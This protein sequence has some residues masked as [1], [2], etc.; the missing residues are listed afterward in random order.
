MDNRPARVPNIIAFRES[1]LNIRFRF[2]E[3]YLFPNPSVFFRVDRQLYDLTITPTFA[4]RIITIT[5]PKIEVNK[6]PN[7]IDYYLLK[8]G[9]SSLMGSIYV[10]MGGEDD[11]DDA[12]GIFEVTIVDDQTIVVYISSEQAV[13]DAIAAKD[14]AE[15]ARDVVLATT[16]DP[17]PAT[18]TSMLSLRQAGVKQDFTVQVDEYQGVD[19]VPYYWNG[20][21]LF[22]YGTE[23]PEE[24][25]LEFQ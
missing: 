3:D 25:I 24:D 22:A 18:F 14:A 13:E 23:V 17:R 19:Q 5:V 4:D 15:A 7:R 8:D 11:G 2:P 16:Y 6:F 1:L 10:Q 21:K 9:E 20:Y 12:N